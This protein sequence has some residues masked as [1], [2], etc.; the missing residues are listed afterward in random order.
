MPA[1][2]FKP[3]TFEDLADFMAGRILS[4]MQIPHSLFDPWPVARE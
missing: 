4:V 1:F 3:R 2:Y